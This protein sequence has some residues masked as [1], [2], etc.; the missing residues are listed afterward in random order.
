MYASRSRLSLRG[1]EARGERFEER[2]PAAE[3]G[4][5]RAR[6]GAP[7]LQ[8]A[9]RRG[10]A[11]VLP[12]RELRAVVHVEGPPR[13]PLGA[14]RLV[15]REAVGQPARVDE[16]VEPLRVV[17][18]DG[19]PPLVADEP[20]AARHPAR[21]VAAARGARGG[22]EERHALLVERHRPPRRQKPRVER[23]RARR[24]R[25]CRV[26]VIGVGEARAPARVDG[27]APARR[28]RRVRRRIRR[29]QRLR[30]RRG[31]LLERQPAGG[32]RA[33]AR[34]A[35]VGFFAAVGLFELFA[36]QRER[37]RRHPGAQR[38]ARRGLRRPCQD[39][40]TTIRLPREVILS[41]A[42][43]GVLKYAS[44]EGAGRG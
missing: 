24:Q 15:D 25:R 41:R 10:G 27:R 11:R 5:G 42:L 8:R 31:S 35:G 26:I 6:A 7:L 43:I 30:V 2:A 13:A 29:P 4:R 17:R 23:R 21:V 33:R 40:E 19:A 20:P 22:H 36:Q 14:R 9:R 39:D 16:G 38:G 3:A 12:R 37:K 18:K 44:N 1:G 28:Q 32:R 34:R